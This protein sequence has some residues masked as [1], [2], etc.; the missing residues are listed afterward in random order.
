MEELTAK[1]RL[2][3]EYLRRVISAKGYAPTVREIGAALGMSS[4]CT[5]QKHLESLEEKGFVRRDRYKR[6]LEIL[7]GGGDRITQSRSVCVP[8]LGRVAGGPPVL[9]EPELDPEML[10]LPLSLLPR[11]TETGDDL[12]A[13][14]VYGQSMVNAGIANGDIVVA[15]RQST[16]RNGDIVVAL[17]DDEAT[18]KTY[19][20]E[21]EGIRLQPENPDF[22]PIITRDAVVIGKVTLSIKRFS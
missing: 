17:L 8:L 7:D 21:P 19:F 16:A 3:F 15:R 5:V 18:V 6:S 9:A 12:F 22:D 2:V 4:S 14:E 10:P 1:Q 11:G 13:L 20:V